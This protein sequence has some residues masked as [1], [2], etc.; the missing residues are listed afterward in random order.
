[1]RRALLALSAVLSVGCGGEETSAP[2]PTSTSEGIGA[3]ISVDAPPA[4]AEE[5][6]PFHDIE[7]PPFEPLPVPPPELEPIQLTPVPEE[8]EA[9]AL[10]E[11]DVSVAA[12]EDLLRIPHGTAPSGRE[13]RVVAPSA[14]IAPS[15]PSAPSAI[16]RLRDR[17]H[18]E[19]RSDPIG[20]KGPRQ[21][22][23][24]ETDAAIRVPIDDEVSLEGGVRV[25]QRDDPTLP[26]AERKST[27]RVGVKVRF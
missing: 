3:P 13:D 26:E 12:L 5:L 2:A 18:L 8:D 16:D 27:P 4:D 22:T 1:M 24:S 14:E 20:P 7:L 11:E 21:G 15:A 25:D 23:R 19:R 10:L 6:T 17:V 9:A